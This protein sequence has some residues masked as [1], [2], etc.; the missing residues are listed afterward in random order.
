MK[1]KTDNGGNRVVEAGGQLQEAKL[2]WMI[3]KTKFTS[4]GY[5]RSQGA[6]S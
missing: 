5:K 3:K 4:R 2:S 6:M 1:N